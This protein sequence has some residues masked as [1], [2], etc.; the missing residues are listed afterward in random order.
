MTAYFMANDIIEAEYEKLKGRRFTYTAKFLAEMKPDTNY[1]AKACHQRYRALVAGTASIPPEL[2]DDPEKRIEEMAE[3]KMKWLDER[4]RQQHE[5][6]QANERARIAEVKNKEKWHKKQKSA[7]D[8]DHDKKTDQRDRLLALL[9]K[10]ER[11]IATVEKRKVRRAARLERLGDQ[12][13]NKRP[14]KRQIEEMKS[15]A[16]HKKVAGI[17]DIKMESSP[18]PPQ[19]FSEISAPA[20]SAKA[21]HAR[22]RKRRGD[23]AAQGNAFDENEHSLLPGSDDEDVATP[24]AYYTAS[25]TGSLWTPARELDTDMMDNIFV[26][27]TPASDH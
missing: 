4:D 26:G 15:A 13:T 19:R 11:E 17:D 14:T 24:S 8:R 10:K 5:A 21:R 12:K 27:G 22:I 7:A 18:P 20:S 25:K 1:S 23:V 9:E 2:D 3:A 6:L 16:L